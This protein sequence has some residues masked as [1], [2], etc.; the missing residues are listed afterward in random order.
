MTRSQS[1]AS[2]EYALSEQ[3]SK[4]RK[5]AKRDRDVRGGQNADVEPDVVEPDVVEPGV[6]EA[7]DSPVVCSAIDAQCEL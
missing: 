6:N 5:A 1:K 4:L 7:S 2:E 3:I